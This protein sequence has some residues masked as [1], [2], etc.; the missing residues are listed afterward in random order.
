MSIASWAFSLRS[1][2]NSARSDSDNE[3]GSASRSVCSRSIFTQFHRV[4][5]AIDRDLATSGDRTAR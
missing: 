4:P 5:S 2:F 1:R 3:S